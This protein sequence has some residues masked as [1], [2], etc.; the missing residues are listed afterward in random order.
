MPTQYIGASVTYAGFYRMKFNTDGT[1]LYNACQVG[2]VERYDFDRCTGILSNRVVY[3]TPGGSINGYWDFEISHDE[4]K[5]Y[6]ARTMLGPL[7]NTTSLMQFPLDP[8]TFVSGAQQLASY[9]DPERGGALKMGP[10][11]KIYFSLDYV[12]NDTCFDYLYCYGTSN[13]TNTT[14]SVINQPDSTYPACDYQPY[15]FYLGGHKS[16]Y[17]LPNNPNYELGKWAGSLCDT[18]T[19]GLPCIIEIKKELRLYYSGEMKTVYI[20]ADK[21]SG[22]TASLQ[23]Y[24]SS[25]QL[26]EELS[27]PINSGYFSYSSSFA[28]QANGVYIIRLITDKEV[29]TGKFAK[30]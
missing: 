14:L 17:G 5:L 15:S 6:S 25:G 28:S 11:G 22:R 9:V 30:Q 21:L 4:T 13:I 26:I 16:Y 20:N 10:D 2:V 19:V 1:H 24:N 27:Q 3:S 7:Q 12:D 18:L 23:F 29:L 8:A